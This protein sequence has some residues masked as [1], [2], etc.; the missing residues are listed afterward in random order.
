MQ[1]WGW[2]QFLCDFFLTSD[3][4]LDSK[5]PVSASQATQTLKF[6]SETRLEGEETEKGS[7]KGQPP[8]HLPLHQ[9]NN[10]RHS[11][12]CITHFAYSLRILVHWIFN[13]TYHFDSYLFMH[14]SDYT[15]IYWVCNDY[16]D[17]YSIFQNEIV[18]TS[19]DI[20]PPISVQKILQNNSIL[21]KYNQK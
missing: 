20:W 19:Y 7:W 9:L 2:H 14:C 3:A 6:I 17:T 1:I 13:F 15:Y 11:N 18:S 4:I 5:I 12:H 21:L 8:T 16:K 10:S